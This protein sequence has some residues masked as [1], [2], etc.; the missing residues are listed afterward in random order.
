M[1]KRFDRDEWEDS[2]TRINR[3]LAE[4]HA[5]E[6]GAFSAVSGDAGGAE[7]PRTVIRGVMTILKKSASYRKPKNRMT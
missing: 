5:R 1:A 3:I 7:Y 4:K 2:L 6:S